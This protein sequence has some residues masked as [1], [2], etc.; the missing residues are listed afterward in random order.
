[1]TTPETPEKSVAVKTL[2]QAAQRTV[3]GKAVSGRVPFD[4]WLRLLMELS[5]FDEVTDRLQAKARLRPI[6]LGVSLVVLVLLT[7]FTGLFFL[8]IPAGIGFVLFIWFLFRYRKLRGLDLSNE[9]RDVLLPFLKALRHDMDEKG[10]M[11]LTLDFSPCTGRSNMVSEE[12]IPPGRYRKLIETIY[13]VEWAQLDVTLADGNRLKM[14]MATKAISHDRHWTTTSVSGK[15]KFKHK[16]KWRM[17]AQVRAALVPNGET[18]TWGSEEV[19]GDFPGKIKVAQKR[20]GRIVRLT[21]RW[22]FKSVG[23]D[24]EALQLTADDLVGLCIQLY[25]MLAPLKKGA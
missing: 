23:D 20:V 14:S 12:Q 6:I 2:S 18:F 7:L 21:Q 22:K 5:H 11:G 1:M 4:Q 3:E 25:G 17:V 24:P 10:G 19:P 9:F 15:T 13:Q 16:R 8:F